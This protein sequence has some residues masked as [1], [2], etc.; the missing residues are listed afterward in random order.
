MFG[1]I[2][3]AIAVGA[4]S[5]FLIKK[6]HLNTIQG[7]PIKLLDKKFNKGQIFGGLLFGFGWA[8]TGACP[9]PIYALIAPSGG[10]AIVILISAVFGT[11]VYGHFREKLPH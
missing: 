11:W 6:F 2:F 7:E 4:T 8:I 5:I 3:T 9:G 10:A 1:T